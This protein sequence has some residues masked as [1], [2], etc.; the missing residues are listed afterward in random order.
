MRR[1][2]LSFTYARSRIY[3]HLLGRKKKYCEED[4]ERQVRDTP[5]GGASPLKISRKFK[6]RRNLWNEDPRRHEKQA[7]EVELE[8]K[9]WG[10]P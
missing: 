3:I 9:E 4:K 10:G 6:P 2:I 1:R 8:K 5:G 7:K